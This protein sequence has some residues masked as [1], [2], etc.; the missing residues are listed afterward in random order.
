M[1]VIIEADKVP[2][3]PEVVIVPA[4][5]PPRSTARI[6]PQR[7]AP[8]QITG[9]RSPRPQWTLTVDLAA[10]AVQRLQDR[11]HEPVEEWA[12]MLSKDLS[13]FTD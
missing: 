5:A 6:A 7:S 1:P 9:Q 8:A 3:P 4:A 11:A 13:E 12:D 10:E 2:T